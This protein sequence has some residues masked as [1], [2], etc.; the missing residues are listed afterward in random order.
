MRSA[1]G[2]HEQGGGVN[3]KGCDPRKC[4]YCHGKNHTVH[5]CWDLHGKH[6]AHQVSLPEEENASQ[7]LK[8]NSTTRVVSIPEEE[9][10]RLVSLQSQSTPSASSTV[11][12]AQSCIPFLN[13]FIWK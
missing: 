8:P 4:T 13:H 1:H 7:S 2:G 6:T 11:T 3:G 5:F 9:Y 10:H 12:L